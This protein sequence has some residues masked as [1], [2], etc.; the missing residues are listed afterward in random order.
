MGK[1]SRQFTI[2][3]YVAP[4]P[5]CEKNG[6]DEGLMA[7]GYRL[8]KEAGFT[9]CYG[10]Y[11]KWPADRELV[12]KAL[13]LAEEAGLQYLISDTD[14]CSKNADFESFLQDAGDYADLPAFAGHLI[15]DEP[16]L[17][18]FKDIAAMK[19]QYRRKFA[20]KLFY[21]NLQPIY[22]APHYLLNGM[23]TQ[24]APADISY[25]QYVEAY[26]ETVRPEVLSF[27]FYPFMVKGM[28]QEYFRQ[29]SLIQRTAQKY[30]V[31]FWVYIQSCTWNTSEAALPTAGELIW[32]VNTSVAYGAQ[33]IQYFCF[34]TPYSN[35]LKNYNVAMVDFYGE[36]TALYHAAARVNRFVQLVWQELRNA[37][38]IG[39]AAYGNAPAPVPADDLISCPAIRQGSGDLLIGVYKREEKLL[40]YV[41]SNR[42]AE[43]EQKICLEFSDIKKYAVLAGGTKTVHKKGHYSGSLQGGDAVLIIIDAP[44]V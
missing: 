36:P 8:A 27:D 13:R 38:H 10:Y 5:P 16:G 7:K 11:E 14:F 6:W 30:G 12:L 28:P 29:L 26:M 40:L 33:G 43:A 20:D 17:M 15:W 24:P 42:T 18:Q 37:L 21:T 4:P 41:V 39:M 25:K 32:Q 34:F 35:S 23:W 44:Q 2:A 31:P 22:S 9:L 19:E 1:M 3:A